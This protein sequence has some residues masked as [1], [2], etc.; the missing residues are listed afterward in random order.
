MEEYNLNN[1]I[2]SV[3][4]A[5]LTNL[6][7]I[8]PEKTETKVI[9]N[10]I[11]SIEEKLNIYL[12]DE[13]KTYLLNYDEVFFGNSIIFKT[14]DPN[15][16]TSQIFDGFYG[17]FSK[18]DETLMGQIKCY[19]YRMPTSLIPIGECPGGNLIC[20]G[21]KGDVIGKVYYWDHENECQALG[22]NNEITGDDI[23]KYW[24]NLLLVADT[25]ID[26]I[27]GLEIDKSTK[28]L[29]D[30]IISSWLHEDL[31]KD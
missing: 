17:V 25:F 14:N 21:V 27:K 16:E 15:N 31:L 30:S 11:D 8:K 4:I 22:D 20:L 18:Y 1:D 9:R 3:L 7:V 24:D 23:E 26:F 2:R 29:D 6:G 13:Y 10:V 19:Y 5:L 28:T 12:S